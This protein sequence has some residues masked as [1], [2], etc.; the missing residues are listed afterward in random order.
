MLGTF[1][2]ES[3]EIAIVG[4]G[5]AGLVTGLALA[6]RGYQIV[7]YEKEQLPGGML[8]SEQVGT[9]LVEHAANSL[10]VTPAM[11]RLCTEVGVRLYTAASENSTKYIVRDRTAK[12]FPP[13]SLLELLQAS[14]T[15]AQSFWVSDDFDASLG[16]WIEIH[17]GTKV[18]EYVVAPVITGVFACSPHELSMKALFKEYGTAETKRLVGTLLTKAIR[19]TFCALT[20]ASATYGGVVEGGMGA[21][22]DAMYRKLLSYKNVEFRFGV[23]CQKLPTAPNICLCIP[24]FAAAELLSAECLK[25]AQLLKEVRY[26]PLVSASVIIPKANLNLIPAGT[27]ILFPAKEQNGV[28]GILFSSSAYPQVAGGDSNKVLLRAFLGGTTNPAALHLSE[29][30]IKE[31]VSHEINALWGFRGD[32]GC[33]WRIRTWPKAIPIYSHDLYNI[34]KTLPWVRAKGR[35]LFASYTG[36]V[37]LRGMVE[38]LQESTL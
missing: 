29:E 18:L 37:S 5:F 26:S 21:F 14:L 12:R 2:S 8:S 4:A 11:H 35:I 16:E 22:V 24:A 25:S 15:F 7:I 13:L 36:S 10:V 17:F 30:S 32:G 3:R 9:F 31:T 19:R 23:E 20:G 33:E 6:K 1:N 38:T 34:W 27:G 28:L